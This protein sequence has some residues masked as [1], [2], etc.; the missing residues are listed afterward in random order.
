M[1][2]QKISVEELLKEPNSVGKESDYKDISDPKYVG[3][4]VWH[5]IHRLAFEAKTKKLQ[6]EFINIMKIICN[7]FPCSVCK[8]HCQEYIKNHPLEKYLDV[9]IEDEN[10]KELLGMFIWTWKF[11]NAVNARLKKPI[12]N[13]NTAY[14]LYTDKKYL[15]CSKSC[16]DSKNPNSET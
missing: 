11:H 6:L 2:T 15:M 4:G 7:K 8:G 10:G 16:L 5:T 3:P 9:Y 12:M 13:W 14:S 1:K